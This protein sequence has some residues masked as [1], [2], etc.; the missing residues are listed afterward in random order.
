MLTAGVNSVIEAQPMAAGYVHKQVIDWIKQMLEFP[1]E[2]GGVL[3]SGGSEAN[4]TALAV[5]RNARAEVDMKAK[6]MQ[7]VQ[8]RMVVYV[9]DGGHH[10][11]E[12]SVELLGIG[13]ENLRWIESDDECRIKLSSLKAAINE[14]KKAGYL[15][16]CIIGNAGTVD[17]G[18]FDD[19]HAL[20]DLAG[21]EKLWFHIDGAFGGWVK[22]SKTHKHL[23]DGFERADSLA[24]DLHKWM[25]MPYGIGCTLVKDR[26][27]HYSTFVYGHEAQYLKS[28]SDLIKEN[29]TTLDSPHSL[30]LPLSREF[31]GLKAYMLLRAHGWGKYGRLIQQNI[32]QARYLGELVQRDPEMELCAPVASNVVCFRF[33]PGNLSEDEL[34]KLNKA[35]AT[36]A[37]KIRFWMISDT[38]VKGNWVLRAAITNHRS[39]REDFDYVFNLVK[40]L[41]Q[42]AIS[43]PQN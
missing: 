27:A 13:S 20:A 19:F 7:G 31:R 5:A 12:R 15:P 4:Y 25:Y 36:E 38:N 10:C 22:I 6:G 35:I 42:K 29:S 9:S 33:N 24:V 11:L 39:K 18:A 34:N 28:G 23:A 32:D 43:H 26:L 16:F 8:R 2:A 37:N 17:A 30:A 40:E 3:V 1:K 21:K 41:G 14:D